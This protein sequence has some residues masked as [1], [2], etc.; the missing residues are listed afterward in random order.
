[1]NT[2]DMIANMFHSIPGTTY[3]QKLSYLS[4][5][6]C[7]ERHQKN[8]P[9]IFKPWNDCDISNVSQF[10]PDNCQCNCRHAA[11]FICRQCPAENI[12]DDTPPS[13]KNILNHI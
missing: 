11:R 2:D 8:K 3:S 12:I 5:C 13:P 1:M 7:C 6:N 10:N 4:S 9:V